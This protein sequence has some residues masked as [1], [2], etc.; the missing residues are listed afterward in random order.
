VEAEIVHVAARLFFRR[1][2]R[3]SR[4]AFAMFVRRLLAALKRISSVVQVEG[5]VAGAV[6][7]G[8]AEGAATGSGA[9]GGGG[10]G[11]S[12]SSA[13][14]ALRLVGSLLRL[15]RGLLLRLLGLG[16]LFLRQLLQGRGHIG[17]A[18][19]VLGYQVHQ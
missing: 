1:R 8:S 6:T 14:S 7:G 9:G 2:T 18:L 15:L 4:M 5:R 11:G 19:I 12:A 3:P 17:P 16:R 13:F 10:T